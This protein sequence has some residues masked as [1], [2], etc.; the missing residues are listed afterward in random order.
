MV[1]LPLSLGSNNAFNPSTIQRATGQA[2]QAPVPSSGAT[3][4]APVPS[5]GATPVKYAALS[6]AKN[7]TGQAPVK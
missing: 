2:G 5:D 4:R 6:F 1:L 3:G 7:L